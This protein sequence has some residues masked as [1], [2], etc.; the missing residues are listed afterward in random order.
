MQK[1]ERENK[2]VDAGETGTG[3]HKLAIYFLTISSSFSFLSRPAPLEQLLPAIFEQ[4]PPEE[5][6]VHPA[7]PFNNLRICRKRTYA[8]KR[9]S[10]YTKSC[11]NKEAISVILKFPEFFC[12]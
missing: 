3:E 2:R 12:D 9:S 6:P 7:S 8:A 4:P 10:V 1:K 5:Q 11:G